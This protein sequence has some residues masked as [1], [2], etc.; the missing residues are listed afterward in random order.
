MI[1]RVK[2]YS[3]ELCRQRPN[4]VFVFGD[5][6]QGVGTGGQAIIRYEPNAYGIPTKKAPH[7]GPSAFF[8]D[9]E[10]DLNVS[11]I[12]LAII[13]IQDAQRRLGGVIILPTDGLGTGRAQLQTRA[14]RTWTYLEAAIQ[15]SLS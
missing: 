7:M 12:N 13:R 6:L 15:V 2:L 14:P 3:T 10:L 5:N 4:D 8:T 9:V 11:A 1:E